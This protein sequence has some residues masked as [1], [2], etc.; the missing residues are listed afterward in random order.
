MTAMKRGQ[1]TVEPGSGGQGEASTSKRPRI[2]NVLE[3]IGDGARGSA[4]SSSEAM[5][6]SS[7]G[8]EEEEE[9]E[10]EAE[11]GLRSTQAIHEK[12]SRR[13]E[14]VAAEHGII[15]RV[16]CYNFMCHEHFSV[17][18]GPLINFIVG[19]NGSGKSAILTALTLCLGGKASA[20]NR[21]QSL[22]SFVKE[23]KESATIIVRIKN[24]G[25]GAYLPDIYGDSVIVER[26]FSRS[27][28]SGFRLKSKSGA[29]VS[30][31]RADLDSI[32]DYFALQMDNP[33]NVL[34]QDM[35]RQF[36]S[37]SSPA[38]KYKFFMKGVQLE[39][40]DVDYHMMEQSIDQLEEKLKDH[41]DQLKVLETNKNNARA[42]LAQSD[43]HESLRER[44]RHL[45]GQT[46]WIQVE[47]QERLRDSLITE[48][49]ETKARI[50]QLQSE[51]EGR[52]E[53][54]QEAD[55]E[56]NEASVALQEA[57]DAQAAVEESKAEIKQRYDEAVKERTGLQAQ[58]AMIREHLMDNKRIIADTQRKIAEEH[59][60]LETLNGGATAA[61]L[62]ELEERRSAAS[63]AKDKYNNH[64]QNADQLQKAISEAEEAV[65]EKSKPIRE[66]K[67][68][69]ND[70][71]NQL[72][73]LMTRDRG[74]QD[75]FPEKMPLLLQAIAAERGFSQP[76]V[77]PLG[78][79]VRLLKP[80]WSSILE[81]AFGATL[82]SFVVTSKRDMNVLSGIMRRVDCVCPI[83]IGNSQGRIDTSGH[84]PD[85]Q[86]DTALRVLEIDDDMVRRQLVINHGIEQML[87]IEDVEEASK[88]MFDGARPRNVKRCYCI[89]S[90]DKRRGIHLAFGR[91]GDPSQSPIPAFT[92]RPRMKTDT[93]IQIRLQ[94][95]VVDSLKRNLGQ[96]GQEHRAAIQHLQRQKQLFSIHQN[97]EHELF[98]ESQRAEDKADDLKDAIDRDSI[99]DGRLEALNLAMKE[100][101]EEMKLHE[102]SFEDCVNAKDAATAKVK[103]IK[104][105][106]AAK[107]AEISGISNNTRR[108]E[109]DLARKVNKRHAALVNK[110]EAI[111]KTDNIKAQVV[112]IERR[113]EETE[114][115][116]ADFI[117]KA[118]MVAPRVSIDAGETEASLAEKLDRLDRDLR[119]YDSQMGA[120]REEIA[121]AAAE[122][123]AKY[124]RSRNETAGFKTLAQ[125][126]KHSLVHRQERWQ[127]FRAHITSRAKIQFIYLLSERGFRGR[128][129]ANHRKKLLDIQV[130]PD[131]TKDG[132]SRG[133]RTLSGGEKSF[134]QICLLL[135]LWEAMGSPIRCLDEFD[136]YMDSVNRKMAIDILMYA[137]RCSVGRQYI[138]IT[139]G[140]RSEITAAPD[141]RVKELAEP[142]RGQRTLSFAQ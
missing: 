82:S 89:D 11:I 29:I 77:G 96:L 113:Q 90:R 110:N 72:R 44:I 76:P 103:E 61:R 102:R 52:D 131:S 122:A 30:T 134:S 46:A 41:M 58:Q 17:E 4:D 37:T 84:E 34:S 132:I 67:A 39:Q 54:F 22:K 140:S 75:G 55:R 69:I 64:R 114:A 117:Q 106:L 124:E 25:D 31:R 97:Q 123:D 120:S 36:L 24:Q 35:A 93:E 60:R 21:G 20:T 42:R 68:E 12:N 3:D 9:D 135:A 5:S 142:E 78:Q 112:Q 105:E 57:K 2:S 139:P 83:F 19:K 33:M 86:F 100:T 66:K 116:I 81:N 125:M 7:E 27:G 70:A 18:L 88:I 115:R 6:S 109:A 104:K 128:L 87:L 62:N 16:D 94:Q 111:A 43:R 28:S 80:K 137:A 121:A 38:E 98:V 8:G 119:R 92:G 65:N 71:E 56:F 23:G 32:T 45:R 129:L 138:L 50:E 91:M 73:T 53:A 99:E 108:A 85:P 13:Q 59:A 133:A 95:E 79:H 49:A 141:V 40:L 107:D 74:Q 126:L 47:E 130:E 1:S 26:H 51:A 15:E 127:K 136:V 14:N 101:E 118:S 63:A 48:V 10:E